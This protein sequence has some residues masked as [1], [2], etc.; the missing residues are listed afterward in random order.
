M[1]GHLGSDNGERQ[2]TRIVRQSQT[3]IVYS[4]FSYME[5]CVQR[6]II[7][8]VAVVDTTLEIHRASLTLISK[9]EHSSLFRDR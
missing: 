2:I 5:E 9:K 8:F 6:F 1:N 4:S 3:P 7:M